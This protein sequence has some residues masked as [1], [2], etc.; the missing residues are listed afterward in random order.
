MSFTVRQYQPSD[1][2][3]ISA[4][5]F[6]AVRKIGSQAY[7]PEQVAAWAPEPPDPAQLHSQATDGRTTLVAVDLSGNVLG[8]GDLEHDGHLDH[9]YCHPDANGRGI[10]GS[11]IEALIAIAAASGLSRVFTEASEIARPL[12]ERKGFK[13]VQRLDFDLR[14]VPIHNY[15]M[16]W[17]APKSEIRGLT[18]VRSWP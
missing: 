9:L 6:G 14:G 1:A 16:E 5:F 2:A 12:F 15:L 8:Y 4:L 13:L 18:N 10:G 17:T 3:A 7:T 11:L